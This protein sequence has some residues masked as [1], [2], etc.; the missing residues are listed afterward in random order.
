MKKFQL[1]LFKNVYGAFT[2]IAFQ[3]QQSIS[4]AIREYLKSPTEK[5]DKG[6][7][8]LTKLSKYSVSGGNLAGNID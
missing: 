2:L 8:T 6:A 3:K 5:K 4:V 7:K 1:Y